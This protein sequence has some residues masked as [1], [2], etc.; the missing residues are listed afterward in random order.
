MKL[1]I[2]RHGN[3]FRPGETARR[4]GK[5]TDLPLVEFEKAK[6]VGT[7]LKQNHYVPSKIISSPLLRTKQTAT[8]IAKSFWPVVPIELDSTFSEIDYGPDENKTEKEV[9]HRLGSLKSKPNATNSEIHALGKEIIE[10]WNAKAEVP[11]GWKVDVDIIQ[12][13][14][15]QFTQKMETNPHNQNIVV[16]TSNGI[17]RFAPVLCEDVDAFA[18]KYPLKIA[19][20]AICVFEKVIGAKF[21]ECRIWNLNPKLH[22]TIQ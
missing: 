9:C 16:V 13:N 8:E 19:T 7:W 18:A 11:P 4:I 12:A 21:W 22:L 5:N 6:A 14:W 10:Q 3:T 17:A 2:V 20:G 1:I 15:Q